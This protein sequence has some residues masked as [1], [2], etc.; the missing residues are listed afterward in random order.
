MR[1]EDA[2]FLLKRNWFW[3]IQEL[4]DFLWALPED[5]YCEIWNRKKEFHPEIQYWLTEKRASSKIVDYTDAQWN[6]DQQA[7]SE[8]RDRQ[9]RDFRKRFVAPP[10]PRQDL[11]DIRDELVE[12]VADK[13]KCLQDAVSVASKKRGYIPPSRRSAESYD[14]DAGVIQAR[15]NLS[16]PENELERV[17]K[18]IESLDKTWTEEKFLAALVRSAGRLSEA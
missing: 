3:D 18:I 2:V 4:F 5:V 12:Q 8:L 14:T 7:I 17:S 10:R 13:K 16:I 15:K 6:A 9:I 1:V 11:D